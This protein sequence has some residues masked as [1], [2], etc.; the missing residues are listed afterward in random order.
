M[1]ALQAHPNTATAI[2][3]IEI[4][5]AAPGEAAAHLARLIDGQAETSGDGARVA[6]APGRGDFLFLTHSAFL[7]RH[8]C[9]RSGTLPV[10]G[11]AALVLQ[12]ADL[13]AAARAVG[14][15]AVA[16]RDGVTVAASRACGVM[17]VFSQT[18]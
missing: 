18:A 15:D 2:S 1:P 7:A 11:A 13:D 5:C 12:V 16:G 14:T 3:C 4:V 6:T 17:L 10:A 9:A 8:P